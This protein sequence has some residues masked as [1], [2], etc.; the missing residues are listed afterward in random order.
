MPG[1]LLGTSKHTEFIHIGF[2]LHGE[3]KTKVNGHDVR[4]GQALCGTKYKAEGSSDVCRVRK[5]TLDRRRWNRDLE[6]E[7][8]PHKIR[9]TSLPSGGNSLRAKAL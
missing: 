1:A 8:V 2:I 4:L 7:E 9:G 3:R 5:A 6:E